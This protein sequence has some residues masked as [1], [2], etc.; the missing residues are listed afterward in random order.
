VKVDRACRL[1][2]PVHLEQ[3]R[4]H[5]DKVR[6]VAP[7]MAARM[8]RFSRGCFASIRSSQATSTSSGVH[9]SLKAAPAALLPTGA[10]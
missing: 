6:F 3:V 10:A 1:E 8:T 9:L 5:V 7:V 4:S 2:Q